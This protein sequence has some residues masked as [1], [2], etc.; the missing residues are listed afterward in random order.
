MVRQCPFVLKES[1]VVVNV[2]IVGE[3]RICIVVKKFVR[4]V[5]QHK[6]SHG[7]KTE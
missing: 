6:V 5:L 7:S 1:G 4:P 3:D 2:S